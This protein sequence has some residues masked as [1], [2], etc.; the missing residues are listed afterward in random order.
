M[1][2]PYRKKNLT[3]DQTTLEKKIS[4]EVWH[5]HKINLNTISLDKVYNLYISI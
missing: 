1:I 4:P 3:V 5:S 2:T